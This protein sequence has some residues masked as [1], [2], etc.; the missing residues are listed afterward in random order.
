MTSA[1]AGE[2]ILIA[3]TG[4]AGTSFLVRYLTELGL[5]T[6]LSRHGEGANWDE[7]ALAGLEDN[8]LADPQG[9]PFVIKSAWS[10]ELITA[11]LASPIRLQAAIMPVRDLRDAAASRTILERQARHNFDRIEASAGVLWESW[12]LTPGGIVYSLS[13]VDQARLIATGFHHTIQQLLEAEIPIIL[14]AFPRLIEDA[15]YLFRRLQPV[16]PPEVTIEAAR[17][18]HARIADRSK[19]RVDAARPVTQLTGPSEEALERQALVRELGMTR[20]A[21][22]AARAQG[23]GMQALHDEISALRAAAQPGSASHQAEMSTR[24]SRSFL[25]KLWHR[26]TGPR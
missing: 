1:E 25:S 19:V 23:A 11:L 14:L 6:N 2:H 22:D 4:R 13:A 8:P 7:N 12:G 21:L 5:D 9:L 17:E 20:L 18:A 15:D 16:L 3:G 10:F 24:Q 26:L